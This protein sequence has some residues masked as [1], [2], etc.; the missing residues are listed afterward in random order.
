[1]WDYT[2]LMSLV[3]HE[4]HKYFIQKKNSLKLDPT[5]LFTYLKN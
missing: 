4:T 3:V 2:F 1:M 5:I